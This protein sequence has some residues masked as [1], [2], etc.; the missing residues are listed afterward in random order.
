VSSPSGTV[1]DAE[2]RGLLAFR[3]QLRHFLH[4]SEQ[5]AIDAGVTPAQYQLLLAVRGHPG[6]APTVGEVAEHLLLRHHS[7]VGLI[8]RAEAA[9]LVERRPDP[10]DHRLVRLRLTAL[11]ARVLRRLAGLHLD[12]LR[13]RAPMLDAAVLNGSAEPDDRG[14]E[15]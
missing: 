1:S 5:Q 6:G 9:K 11:G 4:W 2:Y 14:G 12:E 13:R 3:D 7:V 10:G 8:D 15:S